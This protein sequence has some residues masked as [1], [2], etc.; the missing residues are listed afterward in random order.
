M[1]A[2]HIEKG[3]VVSEPDHSAGERRSGDRHAW[4]LVCK[5]QYEVCAH[6]SF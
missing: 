4:W 6:V 3:L 5:S 2:H 1:V